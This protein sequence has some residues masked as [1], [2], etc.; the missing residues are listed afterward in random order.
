MC[1]RLFLHLAWNPKTA[2]NGS[3]RLLH[4]HQGASAQT[5]CY[6][7]P[8][9]WNWTGNGAHQVLQ[10]QQG[11]QNCLFVPYCKHLHCNHQHVQVSGDCFQL[12]THVSL[13]GDHT[14]IFR[15]LRGVSFDLV[16]CRCHRNLAFVFGRESTAATIKSPVRKASARKQF[17]NFATLTC[18]SL[19]LLARRGSDTNINS[20]H[21]SWAFVPIISP[22]LSIPELQY[23]K[24]KYFSVRTERRSKHLINIKVSAPQAT[25]AALGA[26]GS[27]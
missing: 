26:S 20:Q 6:G 23:A 24:E 19:C 8:G 22:Y 18:V 5:F 14:A 2:Q 16:T 12:Q 7:C 21:G 15:C 10:G 25:R 4:L 9:D 17:M 27:R 1:L 11:Q 3:G 13:H